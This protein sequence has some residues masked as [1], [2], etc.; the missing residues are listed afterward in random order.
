[1][2]CATYLLWLPCEVALARH[3][4]TRIRAVLCKRCRVAT[5]EV[6]VQCSNVTQTA[7]PLVPL[8]FVHLRICRYSLM[9]SP[10]SISSASTVAYVVV[11]IYGS[12]QLC[13]S[14]GRSKFHSTDCEAWNKRDL[15]QCDLQRDVCTAGWAC[16]TERTSKPRRVE[17][18]MAWYART[19]S[20][21]VVL[22][23][24]YLGRTLA[25]ELL[26]LLSCCTL[27]ASLLPF[28]SRTSL[29]FPSLSMVSVGAHEDY[30]LDR[31]SRLISG[32]FLRLHCLS[33]IDCLH[34]CS[35]SCQC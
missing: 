34:C 27:Y 17:E 14:A 29:P 9:P 24:F 3:P 18:C 21:F 11:C 5:A 1:M 26:L 4:A 32:I 30:I 31:N 25:I 15:L 6:C 19:P 12:M 7:F 2:R 10:I 28:L 13:R 23:F 35:L 8:L 16:P 20:N 22:L 33:P